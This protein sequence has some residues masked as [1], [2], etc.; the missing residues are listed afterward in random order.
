MASAEQTADE[1]FK[2]LVIGD[3]DVGKTSLV[4][5]FVDG[6]FRSQYV[7]TVGI[8]FRNKTIVWNDKQ[9][10]LRIWDTGEFSFIQC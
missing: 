2:I 5:R 9:I 8:D 7:P 6:S 10:Q 3:S 1:H 4:F